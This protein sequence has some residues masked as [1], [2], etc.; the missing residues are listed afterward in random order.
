MKAADKTQGLRS[1]RDIG[2]LLIDQAG[3]YLGIVA[4]FAAAI[5]IA[6]LIWL[7]IWWGGRPVTVEP[8]ERTVVLKRCHQ[9]G[10]K[11]GLVRY[12]YMRHPFCSRRCAERFKTPLATEILRRKKLSG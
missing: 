8:S 10:G 4:T 11:F 7:L 12:Y 1:R 3:I 9:C 6:C 2:R 5:V